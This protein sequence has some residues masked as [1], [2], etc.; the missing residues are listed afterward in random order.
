MSFILNAW[1][2]LALVSDL[3]DKPIRRQAVGL[4]IAL[5]RGQSGAVIA[6]ENRCP[7][8]FAPLHLGTIVGDSIDCPYHGLRFSSAG[9]CIFNPVG[10]GH[11]PAGAK[12]RVFPVIERWN[13]IWVWTG[14]PARADA[15]QIPELPFAVDGPNNRAVFGELQLS[16]SYLHGIDNAMD[17]A[18]VPVLH[19]STLESGILKTKTKAWEDTN[20]EIWVDRCGENTPPPPLYGQFWLLARGATPTH[21]DHWT[22]SRWSSPCVVVNY[23]G[24]G[25]PGGQRKDGVE[26]LV[27]H[28][29]IPKDERSTHYIWGLARSV[30]LDNPDLDGALKSSFEAVVL[31]EDVPMMEN[32]EKYAGSRDLDQ[33]GAALLAYDHALTLVRKSIKRRIATEQ[34]VEAT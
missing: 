18:H 19:K 15:T 17:A 11:V 23:T 1:Y 4:Q 34:T 13:F 12:V 21:V 5:F 9:R 29:F 33:A 28:M 31:N 2:P 30:A 25:S 26:I 16:M 7:H 14:E 22:A 10:D 6:V 3:N 8:R 32:V 24:I 27:I 20:G